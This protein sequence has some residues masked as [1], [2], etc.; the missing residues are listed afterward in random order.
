MDADAAADAMGDEAEGL[1]IPLVWT[2]LDD[3]SIIYANQFAVQHVQ[4]SFL[5]SFG[6]V[7]P[8]MLLGS[9][10]ARLAQARQLTQVPVRTLARY[11]LSREDLVTF[12]GLLTE[13]LKTF[14]ATR[15][16]ESTEREHHDAS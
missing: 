8:P 15:E 7:S 1:A 6:Q 12:I 10:E 14:D 16:R 4:S 9:R 3:A 13:N 2:G 5:V 11:A